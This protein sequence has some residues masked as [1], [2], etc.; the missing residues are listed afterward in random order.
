MVSTTTRPRKSFP[1]LLMQSRVKTSWRTKPSRTTNRLAWFWQNLKEM[2]KRK[3]LLQKTP[4]K[5]QSYR[6]LIWNSIEYIWSWLIYISK[7]IKSHKENTSFPWLRAG[8]KWFRIRRSTLTASWMNWRT[9]CINT[10]NLTSPLLTTRRR[11]YAWK[12]ATRIN[13]W[14]NPKHPRFWS[15]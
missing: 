12:D 5:I 3:G 15:T 8:S 4:K 13:T 7:Q 11:C 2:N 9:V 1:N 6:R 10:K 14:T